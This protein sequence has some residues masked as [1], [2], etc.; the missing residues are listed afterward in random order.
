MP[1]IQWIRG[2]TCAMASKR[3]DI[4]T[5]IGRVR[6][7]VDAL[8]AYKPGKTAEQAA[9]DLSIND[10][11]K[12]NSNENPYPT[13]AAV[14][15]AAAQACRSSN[16]YCDHGAKALREALAQRLELKTSQVTV[17]GGSAAL[18]YQLAKAVVDPGDEVISPWISFEAYPIA[19]QLMAGN[20]VRV[21]LDAG[22]AFDLDAVAEAMTPRTKLVLLANPNNPTGTAVSTSALEHF[23]KRIPGD[24]IVLIDEAYIEFADPLL[25]DPVSDLL[26]RFDNVAIVRTFSKAY[27]LA[28]LRVGYMMAH[29][30]AVAAVDKCAIPF[31]VSSA[32]QAAALAALDDDVSAE[33]QQQVAHIRSERSRVVS[34]LTARGWDIPEPQGNFIWLA[35]GERSSQVCLGLEQRGVVIRPFPGFGIRVTVGTPAQNDRFLAALADTATPR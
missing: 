32:A 15:E 24:V 26:P 16:L 5:S 21:P 6:P 7:A 11:I 9:R 31:S 1:L 2:Q 4:S 25:G 29:Q 10:A 13:P 28:G 17:G 19:V 33:F 27:G 18:L 35:L 14:V 20:L 34:E 22:H 23:V 3:T 30:Q 8:P 12:L